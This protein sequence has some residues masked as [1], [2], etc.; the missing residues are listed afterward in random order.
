MGRGISSSAS[1]PSFHSSSTPDED[2]PT[3]PCLVGW[4]ACQGHFFFLPALKAHISRVHGCTTDETPTGIR[5][6]PVSLPPSRPLDSSYA[7]RMTDL[8]WHWAPLA[9]VDIM[10]EAASS[11]FP[12]IPPSHI[13]GIAV[14]L[15]RLRSPW[16]GL[17]PKETGPATQSTSAVSGQAAE[18]SPTPLH[19]RTSTAEYSESL[20][21]MQ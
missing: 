12:Q 6:M 21:I 14:Y 8:L 4:G 7:T 2:L 16:D 20:E 5:P 3:Y 9:T 10:V 13:R 11:L 1:P 18:G 19:T 17:G 15:K